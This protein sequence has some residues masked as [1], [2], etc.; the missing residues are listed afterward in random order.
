MF[1]NIFNT[2]YELKKI[3]YAT[4]LYYNIVLQYCFLE[5]SDYVGIVYYLV[6]CVF[7][8]FQNCTFKQTVDKKLY[9]YNFRIK[10]CLIKHLNTL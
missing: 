10:L 8:F 2:I 1:Q 3:E 5:H 4:T 6:H 9:L 7:I